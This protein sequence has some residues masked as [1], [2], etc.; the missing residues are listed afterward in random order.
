LIKD[1]ANLALIK[2]GFVDVVSIFMKGRVILMLVALKKAK[3]LG[4]KFVGKKTETN[5]QRVVAIPLTK[6]R[7]DE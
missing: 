3:R 6:E 7:K 4:W 5:L 2:E 1:I